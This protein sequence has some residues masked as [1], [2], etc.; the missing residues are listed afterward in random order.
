MS[1]TRTKGTT[2]TID[3][4]HLSA[5]AVSAREYAHN[6]GLPPA[7]FSRAASAQVLPVVLAL[8]AMMAVRDGH[9]P[10]RVA[11]ELEL[12]QAAAEA[13]EHAAAFHR[14]TDAP[15]AHELAATLTEA[16]RDQHARQVDRAPIGQLARRMTGL[17][18][19][20]GGG[21]GRGPCDADCR[22]CALEREL[23]DLLAASSA[24]HAPEPVG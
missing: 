5:L 20:P 2:M 14:L 21:G 16:Q 11:A 6:Q 10:A 7:E 24:D 9:A 13:L 22:K 19:G 23:R 17:K 18:H 1:E 8:A 12:D 4:A 3:T 15:D